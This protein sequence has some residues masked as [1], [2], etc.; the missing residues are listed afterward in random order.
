MP[1]L[2][3]V[4]VVPFAPLFKSMLKNLT[5]ANI[6]SGKAEAAKARHGEHKTFSE[7]SVASTVKC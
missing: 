2:W 6:A 5:K 1:H 7:I 4:P 3:G